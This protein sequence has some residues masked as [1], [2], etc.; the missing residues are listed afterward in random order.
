MFICPFSTWRAEPVFYVKRKEPAQKLN[1][2]ERGEETG[3]GLRKQQTE[4]RGWESQ[5]A[6]ERTLC[7][8][9]AAG[10][11]AGRTLHTKARRKTKGASMEAS[12]RSHFKGKNQKNKF[13]GF[14][15]A[16]K[17]VGSP[18]YRTGKGLY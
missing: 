8:S 3:R 9:P 10:C 18:G 13:P 7:G 16:K 4:E 17:K 1:R 6:G 12:P 15:L 11:V 5:R 14:S 2:T